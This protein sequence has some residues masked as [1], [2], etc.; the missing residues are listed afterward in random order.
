MKIIYPII[1]FAVSILIQ[2]G[3]FLPNDE[4]FLI[5]AYF[6]LFAWVLLFI[7][8]SSFCYSK[9]VLKKDRGRYLYTLLYSLTI[10]LSYLVLFFMD[11]ESYLYA[12]GI[13]AWSE[14]WALLGL[15]RK[16]PN[17]EPVEQ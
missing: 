17:N 12:L 6:L 10:S 4:A 1:S 3:V 5:L 15:I 13:F 8:I 16:R 11:G 2:L 9:K 7:P 14:I